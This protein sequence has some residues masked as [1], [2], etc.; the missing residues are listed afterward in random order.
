MSTEHTPADVAQDY[1][2]S[3]P[4]GTVITVTHV[5]SGA[6]FQLEAEGLAL[7]DFIHHS[8]NPPVAAMGGRLNRMGVVR[9]YWSVDRLAGWVADGLCRIELAAPDTTKGG[10][11]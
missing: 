2:M 6:S 8:G 3:L 9:K 11:Q 1:L 4:R 7:R 10:A 5:S